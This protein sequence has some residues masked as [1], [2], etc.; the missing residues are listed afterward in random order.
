MEQDTENVVDWEFFADAEKT[1]GDKLRISG[2]ASRR[3]FRPWLDG[4]AHE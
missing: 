3:T 1:L 2:S 4:V